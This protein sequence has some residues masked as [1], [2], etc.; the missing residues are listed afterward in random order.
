MIGKEPALSLTQREGVDENEYKWIKFPFV[1]ETDLC[2][3]S[4]QPGERGKLETLSVS[5]KSIPSLATLEKS[6]GLVEWWV[7]SSDIFPLL[8][9]TSD[10]K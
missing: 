5:I 9:E 10:W 4:A 6:S 1:V 2:L 7:M 8:L 3:Q